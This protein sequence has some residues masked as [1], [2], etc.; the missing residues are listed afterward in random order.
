MPSI[1]ALAARWFAGSPRDVLFFLL[2]L[3]DFPGNVLRSDRR[4]QR[5][6]LREVEAG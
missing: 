1:T 2:R 4:S 3:T 6:P 5:L